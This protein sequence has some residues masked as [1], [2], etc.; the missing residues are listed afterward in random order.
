MHSEKNKKR[1]TLAWINKQHE[2]KIAKEKKT[3]KN[4]A[5]AGEEEE[6]IKMMIFMITLTVF[7][8]CI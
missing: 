5:Q 8:A 7:G 1:Q 6:L 2:R 3:E 4:F